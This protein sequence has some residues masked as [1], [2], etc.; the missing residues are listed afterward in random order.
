MGCSWVN[1][2]S[3]GDNKYFAVGVRKDKIRV[4]LDLRTFAGLRHLREL[5]R[6][7]R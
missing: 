4:T 7:G 6:L 1:P 5:D 2:P 3:D